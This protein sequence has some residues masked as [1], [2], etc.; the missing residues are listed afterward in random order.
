ME[1]VFNLYFHCEGCGG[2]ASHM[3][4]MSYGP[5]HIVNH[6][7]RESEREGDMRQRDRMGG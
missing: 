2:W 4:L 3:C 7:G 5:L 6:L 1:A